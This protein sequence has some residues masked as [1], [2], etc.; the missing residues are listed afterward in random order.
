MIPTRTSLAQPPALNP[1]EPHRSTLEPS[2]LLIRFSVKGITFSVTSDPAAESE[3]PLIEHSAGPRLSA[4][5]THYNN[6]YPFPQEEAGFL[7]LSD[8]STVSVRLSPD[9]LR[10]VD[11]VLPDTGSAINLID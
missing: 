4:I 5:S 1:R 2:Q 6:D 10:T 11:L 9:D 8:L 7:V 3:I